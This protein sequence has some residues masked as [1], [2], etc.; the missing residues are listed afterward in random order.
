MPYRLR[1]AAIALAALLTLPAAAQ[2]ADDPVA[3][4]ALF[5]NTMAE[6]GRTFSANC[7]GCHSV[8]SRRAMLSGNNDPLAALAFDDAFGA[9]VVAITG[10]VDA[11]AQFNNVLTLQQV[12]DLSAYIADTPR[13]SATALDFSASAVNTPSAAQNVDLRHAVAVDETLTVVSVAISGSGAARFTRSSD[14]CD[15]QTLAAGASCRVSLGFSSPDTAGH[16]ASLDFTLRQGASS[17]TF[18][19]SVA[20]NGVA[21]GTTPPPPPAGGSDDGGG[22]LGLGWLAALGAAVAGLS[23]RRRG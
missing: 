22:A 17:T 21:S 13:T 6:T 14:T 3:G 2:T 20:L 9:L 18:T 7:S 8:Q 23:R 5:D 1:T 4:R 11:M 15:T 12:R 19:R 16:T 10:G